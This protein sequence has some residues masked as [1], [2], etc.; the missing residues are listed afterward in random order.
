MPGQELI[1]VVTRQH[2]QHKTEEDET[3]N[4]TSSRPRGWLCRCILC[5][6][7]IPGLLDH[8]CN[9]ERSGRVP[10][11]GSYHVTST[12]VMESNG[13]AS[14]SKRWTYFYSALQLAIQRSAHKWRSVRLLLGYDLVLLTAFSSFDDFVECFSLW[15]EESPDGASSVFNTISGY[16]ESQITVCICIYT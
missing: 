8:S 10:R 9:P 2:E 6:W 4:R 1:A 15:A 14:G 12:F 3:R 5:F 16:Q 13:T 11:P 7:W